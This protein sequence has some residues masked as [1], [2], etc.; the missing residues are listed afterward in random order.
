MRLA[1]VLADW[2]VATRWES[3]G[4]ARLDATFASVNGHHELGTFLDLDGSRLG[5]AGVLHA[6][7]VIVEIFSFPFRSEISF[8]FSIDE[9][10]PVKHCRCLGFSSEKQGCRST[11]DA[12]M[13]HE[14]AV[15]AKARKPCGSALH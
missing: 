7:D 3:S 15:C 8:A 1:G 10:D 2:S 4:M 11:Q 6:G 13:Y 9:V 5:T 12:Q 14:G